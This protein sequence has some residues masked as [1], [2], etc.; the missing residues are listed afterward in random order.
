MLNP[1]YVKLPYET[2]HAYKNKY[3]GGAGLVIGTGVSTRKLLP[4]KDNLKK[5][6]DVIVG[7]NFAIKDFES[8]MD[9]HVV[10]EKNPVNIYVEMNKPEINNRSDLPRVFNWKAIHKYPKNLNF[11]K[12]TRN[13]FNGKPDIRKYKH[14]KTEGLLTGPINEDGLSVGT[15]VMQALH[16]ICILGCDKVYLAGADF[17]FSKEYDH[18]Y[19]DRLYRGKTKDDWGT[20]IIEVVHND[21]KVSDA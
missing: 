14:N 13:S 8:Q 12:M 16:L 9:F 1:N 3:S 6:F 17:V 11:I 5:H 10:A 2:P 18:Y 19:K 7:V 4:H 15:V 21:K 20:P